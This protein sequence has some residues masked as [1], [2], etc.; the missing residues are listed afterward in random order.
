MKR[1]RGRTRAGRRSSMELWSLCR[2]ASEKCHTAYAV[3]A[4]CLVRVLLPIVY[5]HL[6]D[7]A[8]GAW[9]LPP[10]ARIAPA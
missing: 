5:F 1:R 8:H 10:C 2:L 3:V 7:R 9:N 6:I 4:Q